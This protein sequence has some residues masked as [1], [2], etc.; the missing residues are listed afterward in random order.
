MGRRRKAKAAQALAAEQAGPGPDRGALADCLTQ[1]SKIAA[2]CNSILRDLLRGRCVELGSQD[3]HTLQQRQASLR[4]PQPNG[5]H[6]HG[7]HIARGA[8]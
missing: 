1:T 8:R 6:A 3:E 2:E 4:N 5:L 7:A